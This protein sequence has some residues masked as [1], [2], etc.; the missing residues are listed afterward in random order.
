MFLE[1]IDSW[2][3]EF[4]H[5]APRFWMEERDRERESFLSVSVSLFPFD[6]V[7]FLLSRA[8]L[9]PSILTQ[10]LHVRVVS[11]SE[12]TLQMCVNFRVDEAEKK[13]LVNVL[14]RTFPNSISFY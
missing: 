11:R 14:G 7:P 13:L 6:S 9:F 3:R 12:K 8:L 4:G 10:T 1:I 5:P 2:I